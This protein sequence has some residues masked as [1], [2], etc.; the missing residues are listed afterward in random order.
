[1]SGRWWREI[2]HPLRREQEEVVDYNGE[3]CISSS[4][5]SNRERGF[6]PNRE[7]PCWHLEVPISHG[8]V[9]L[10]R[11]GLF[12]LGSVADR[13]KL[14][15]WMSKIHGLAEVLVKN[16]ECRQTQPVGSMIQPLA[17]CDLCR[18]CFAPFVV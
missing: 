14:R 11:G 4:V 8:F 3:A 7:A 18:Y 2:E 6:P 1:M 16:D 9:V 12:R 15:D 5:A 17:N 10:R 13:Q